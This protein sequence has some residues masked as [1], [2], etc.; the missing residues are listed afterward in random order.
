MAGHTKAAGKSVTSRAL[1]VLGA[2]DQE[3]PVLGLSEIA[4]RSGTPVATCHRLL[5]ELTE[6]GALAKTTDGRYQ[7]GYRLWTLG[8]LAP[9]Q[10][11]LREVAAPYMHDVLFATRH[12]VNL[13]VLEDARALLLERIAGTAVGQPVARVGERLLL[14]TSAGGKVL[15]AYAPVSVLEQAFAELKQETRHSITDPAK[16]QRE[17]VKIRE[18]GYATTVEEHALGTSG[19]AVP[20]FGAGGR[21]IAALGAVGIGATPPPVARTLPALQVAAKAIGR[22]LG[23]TG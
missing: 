17:I 23:A 9:V 10:K 14:H 4:R 21:V 7:I 20:V 2:F 3:N 1:N 11:G 16:L 22:T 13:F 5:G 12:V 15:L 18:Q 6:W 8:M 19:L